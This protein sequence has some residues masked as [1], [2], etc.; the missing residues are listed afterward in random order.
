[1]IYK[2]EQRRLQWKARKVGLD[3]N[4][5]V[6]NTVIGHK[7]LESVLHQGRLCSEPDWRN[8]GCNR[9]LASLGIPN[10]GLHSP[11]LDFSLAT[12]LDRDSADLDCFRDL[13]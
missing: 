2:K 9:H 3:E 7:R 13:Y 11:Y 1:M 4:A 8:F 10:D 5:R 6:R 12:I